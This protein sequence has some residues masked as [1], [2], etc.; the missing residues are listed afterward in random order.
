M[1]I[2]KFDKNLKSLSYFDTKNTLI[3]IN[4]I[5]VSSAKDII[6]KSGVHHNRIDVFSMLKFVKSVFL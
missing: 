2:A 5:N 4:C 3:S 6:L 1:K